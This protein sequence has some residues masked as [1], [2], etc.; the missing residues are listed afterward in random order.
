MRQKF[1]F[2]LASLV[3]HTLLAQGQITNSIVY[4]LRDGTIIAAGQSADGDLTLSG[5]YNHHGTQYGLNMKVDGEINITVA[6]SS[7][8]RF[9]G[10]QYSGLNMVGTAVDDGDLGTHETQVAN[11]LA[12]TYDALRGN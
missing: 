12:D 3:L 1:Y 10:S 11:D 2:L 4:D 6:G 5:N 8:I 9:L 7:T